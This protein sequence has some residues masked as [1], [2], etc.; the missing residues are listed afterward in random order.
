MLTALA[1]IFGLKPAP[2]RPPSRRATPAKRTCRTPPQTRSDDDASGAPAAPAP[3]AADPRV[4]ELRE[5][6]MAALAKE[7]SN[8]KWISALRTIARAADPQQM[9]PKAET[10]RT[11]KAIVGQEVSEYARALTL[12]GRRLPVFDDTLA[13]NRAS[14]AA[15]RADLEG[16]ASTDF[17]TWEDARLVLIREQAQ[18]RRLG[19]EPPADL[20]LTARVAQGVDDLLIA[21]AARLA[22]RGARTGGAQGESSV[23]HPGA[24]TVSTIPTGTRTEAVEEVETYTPPAGLK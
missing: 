10:L 18:C 16:R 1:R 5:R 11:S 8:A 9:K 15:I 3:V 21:R 20:A 17:E 23:G 12:L 2:K 6:A 22:R 4:A 14:T 7:D 13:S 24:V 19:I